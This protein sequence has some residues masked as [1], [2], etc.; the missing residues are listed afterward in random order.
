MHIMH[1]GKLCK[2]IVLMNARPVTKVVGESGI[3][4]Y[5]WNHACA[6]TQSTY[7]SALLQ[8]TVRK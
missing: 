6:S 8:P 7:I 3:S 4:T 2:S 1:P 5:I